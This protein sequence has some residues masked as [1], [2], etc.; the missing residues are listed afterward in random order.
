M[1]K[2]VSLMLAVIMAL[3]M[4]M[5]MAESSPAM[6]LSVLGRQRDG[7]TF[8]DAKTTHAW[9]ALE[10]M[11]AK[12]GLKVE[13]T[14]VERDQYN[15]VLNAQIASG[16]IPEFFYA[17][18]LSDADCINLIESGKLMNIGDAL[19]Y[20]NGTAKEAF[21]ENGLYYISRQNNTYT[22]GNMYFFGNVSKQISVENDVFGP[23]NTTANNWGMLIRQDWLD[24]LNLPMPTT[25]DE[26]INTLVAF[27]END[28]NGN[29]IKDE[30]LCLITGSSTSSAASRISYDTGVAQW[31]GLAPFKWSLDRATWQ[32]EVPFLQEGFVPYVEFLRKC[33]DAGVLF[34]GDSV[35]RSS[36]GSKAG[37]LDAIM[38]DDCCSAYYGVMLYDFATQPEQ[39][40]YT[41]MPAI[42]AVED[43]DPV[44]ISSVGYKVWSL[45]GFSA[46]ADPK[47]V[48]AFL[49]T[50]CSKDY[51]VW[52]T[53]G[54][55]GETYYID[56]ASGG[57]T[58]TA[59]NKIADILETKKARGY[60]L[61]IDSY[62]PDASQI[63]WYQEYYGPLNWA[64]NADFL[65]S[66]YYKEVMVPMYTENQ[67]KNL[68][69][70]CGQ[71]DSLLM[72]NMNDDLD[73]TAPMN[74]LEEADI[75]SFYENDLI[76]YM[77]EH[78]T[79]LLTGQYSLDEYPTY[80]QQMKDLGLDEVTA[81]RQA[82]Y[83]R[84]KVK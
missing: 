34:L 59:S 58:F 67:L 41:L 11:F 24:R 82:Q 26:F 8:E 73:M 37:D 64:S 49:D 77:D 74:T 32:T 55:E 83:D 84:L 52:I 76:T 51:A 13:Y 79:G 21:S 45:W 30:R 78:F 18:S 66:R 16:N 60:P 1:K 15:T 6:T 29:G 44:M 3:P 17:A 75:L 7:I 80:V 81:V 22:D 4:A 72:Y 48:A 65:A 56:Q 43:I 28:M 69:K 54:V 57:Y 19:Q 63:G 23:C 68:V 38:Q 62:L 33:I 12:N 25:M 5:A 61:V 70:W 50:I 31:F 46:K 71:A 39:A 10:E 36:T 14:V 40:V 47:A 20:S 2:L 9:T 53:F 35:S 42:K 27:Q